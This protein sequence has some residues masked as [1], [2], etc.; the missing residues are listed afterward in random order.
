MKTDVQTR[1][2]TRGQYVLGPPGARHPGH[3]PQRPSR[4]GRQPDPHRHGGVGD[5]AVRRVTAAGRR[6]PR[7]RWRPLPGNLIDRRGA[8]LV[9]PILLAVGLNVAAVAG[10]ADIAGFHAVYASLSGI[11]WPWLCAVPAA[12]TGMEQGMLA[13][14]GCAASIAWL[15]LGLS[16]VPMNF[17]L[18]WAVI[19]VPAFAAA[20]CLSSRYGSGC[21][22]GPAGGPAP[23]SSWATAPE[24][25]SP[26]CIVRCGQCACHW[27]TV[28]ARRVTGRG[29]RA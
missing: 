14:Y 9:P 13:R 20:F 11:R 28:G 26:A 5:Q 3:L 16:G 17:T 12:L 4:V 24:W 22:A 29:P 19:P 10:L 15:S 25:C 18:P 8:A 23:R 7:L 27:C 1:T 21:R 2:G 6:R